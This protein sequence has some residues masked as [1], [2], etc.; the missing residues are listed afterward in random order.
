MMNRD[1]FD[2][3]FVLELANNHWG[4]VQRGI[5][6]I[7]SYGKIVRFNNIR[8]AMKLQFRDMDTFVHKDFRD[9]QDVRYIKK[10][11]DTRLSRDDFARLVETIRRNN[12]I[13]MATPF[14][15]A[16]VDFCVELKLPFLKLASSDVNDWVLIE[17][18]A[19][20]R[21]PVL[22]SMGG[23][24]EKDVD[25]LV[26]FF[27][28]RKIPMALNHC[29]SIYPSEDG[30]LELNQID[31]LRNRYPGHTIGFST[32]EHRDWT[33]SVVIAYAKGARTFERHVDI[34]DGQYPVTPYCSLPQHVDRWFKAFKKAKEMCGPPGTEKRFVPQKEMEYLQGLVRGVYAKTDLPVGHHLD[35]DDVYMAI[36]LQKGQLSC[37]ELIRG[38]VLLRPVP[39]DKPLLIDDIES[40]YAHNDEL[41]ATIF[42]RG[43]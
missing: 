12:M 20:T 13:P 1:I 29:V 43:L 27:E 28:N 37:R 32:H 21:L 24:S 5:N 23:S 6:I 39:K 25:D 30:E 8:A 4:S 11:M 17:K 26:T 2:E 10:T 14:D 40:P 34:D 3:L 38:E 41:K 33:Y 7:E 9:R 22:A 16:S 35:D 42:A 31:Y 36:P 18:M 15:E 19:R